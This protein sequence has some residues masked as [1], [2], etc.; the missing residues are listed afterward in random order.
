MIQTLSTNTPGITIQPINQ[1]VAVIKY[2]SLQSS[3]PDPSVYRVSQ[4]PLLIS[5]SS[6][7]LIKLG[8]PWF[9]TVLRIIESYLFWLRKSCRPCRSCGSVSPYL[10]M[11]GAGVKD[12]DMR[13][14]YTIEH[15]RTLRKTPMLR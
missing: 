10:S 1:R 11:Y 7:R 15:F 6:F 2:C 12:P 8:T 13:K 3:L 4:P 9:S 14:R 5:A